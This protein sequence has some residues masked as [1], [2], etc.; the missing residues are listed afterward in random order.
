[1]AFIDQLHNDKPTLKA[2]S[3][4]CKAWTHP[5]RLHLLSTVTVQKP[6]QPAVFPYVRH[7][8]LRI[9]VNEASIWDEIMTLLVGFH[10]IVSLNIVLP[11]S[12]PPDLMNAQSWSTLGE[13]FSAVTS[14]CFESES[15]RFVFDNATSFARMVCAFPRL[16]KLRM[17]STVL[18]TS[19]AAL[20]AEL[21]SAT[22]LRLSPD[23]HTLD[24]GHNGIGVV[25]D[26]LL[27]LPTPPALRH[28][29]LS[30]IE[31]GDL[32]AFHKFIRVLGDGLESVMLV[33][34]SQ[35]C[36]CTDLIR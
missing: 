16:Q 15:S 26:W 22:T 6:L 29:Y 13:N 7:L 18:S 31:D 28:I 8:N 30:N 24:I 32:A 21:P 33:A 2:C 17:R 25:L 19:T 23:F 36:M 10:R 12:Y 27:S 35:D 4:V 1:M 11:F 14:L 9:G 34:S 3:L 20:Q 5:A